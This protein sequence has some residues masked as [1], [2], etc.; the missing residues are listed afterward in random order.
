VIKLRHLLVLPHILVILLN[1][2]RVPLS[3]PRREERFVKEHW[4]GGS[5]THP[6]ARDHLLHCRLN[7]DSNLNALVYD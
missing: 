6:E 1:F 2:R 7:D 5:G 3:L 4:A